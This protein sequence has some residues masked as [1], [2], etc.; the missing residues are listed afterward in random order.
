MP[1]IQYSIKKRTITEAYITN[2]LDKEEG[3]P[4]HSELFQ[5]SFDIF[6]SDNVDDKERTTIILTF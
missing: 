1:K 3:K 6:I 4:G 2:I 5:S